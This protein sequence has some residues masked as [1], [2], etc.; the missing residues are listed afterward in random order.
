[1]HRSSQPTGIALIGIDDHAQNSIIVAPGANGDLEPRHVTPEAL[2]GSQI[3]CISLEIPKVTWPDAIRSA[4]AV[5]A[6]VKCVKGIG[7]K[8]IVTFCPCFL[9]K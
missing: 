2:S 7:T 3:V 6:L 4:R 5:G 8:N 1:M 9:Y